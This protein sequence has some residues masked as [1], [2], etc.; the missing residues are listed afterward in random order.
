ME[1][2]HP[3]DQPGDSHFMERLR[4]GVVR[5]YS[6]EKR[7]GLSDGSFVWINLTVSP[8]WQPGE[9]PTNQPTISR[10]SRTLPLASWLRKHYA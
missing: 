6:I 10:S 9:Q 1:L 3:D 5:E 4:A 2:T 7:L 8:M